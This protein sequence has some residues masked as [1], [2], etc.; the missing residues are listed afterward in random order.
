MIESRSIVMAFIR[1]PGSPL[2]PAHRTS[3]WRGRHAAHSHAHMC[4]V[5]LRGIIQSGGSR[6]HEL[7]KEH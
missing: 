4:T 7:S 2:Q 3:G 5:Q 6:E 1:L